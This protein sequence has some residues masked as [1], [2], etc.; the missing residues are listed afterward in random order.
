ME[1]RAGE[2]NEAVPGG[3]KH[4]QRVDV[5]A[6]APEP[7]ETSEYHNM[8]DGWTTVEKRGCRSL[9]HPT[10]G[11]P[12]GHQ[13]RARGLQKQETMGAGGAAEPK[14]KK[15]L[16]VAKDVEKA[17]NKGQ[18]KFNGGSVEAVAEGVD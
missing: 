17:T 9:V 1:A 14:M 18:Q 4:V 6:T 11:W 8:D 5:I 7:K 3:C 12:D 2:T 13:G 15:A 10:K 16:K